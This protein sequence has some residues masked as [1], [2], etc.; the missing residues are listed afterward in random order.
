MACMVVCSS[1]CT[2]RS[3]NVIAA[4]RATEAA[5][6]EL[7]SAQVAESPCSP[8]PLV[9][10][11]WADASIIGHWF[12]ELDPL[13]WS[14]WESPSQLKQELR[15]FLDSDRPVEV[16][17]GARRDSLQCITK[18]YANAKEALRHMGADHESHV[19]HARRAGHEL[20]AAGLGFDADLSRS[21][22]LVS[23]ASYISDTEVILNWTCASCKASGFK[24][25]SGR[26]FGSGSSV[27]GFALKLEGPE[28]VAQT[29]LLAFRGT[30]DQNNLWADLDEWQSKLPDDWRCPSCFAHTGFLNYWMD[31]ESDVVN[32]LKE[33]G[34]ASAQLIITGHSLGGALATLGAWSLRQK[35]GFL[36]AAVYTYESPRV[37]TTEFADAWDT[38]I[39]ATTPAFRITF[40]SDPVTR[41]PCFWGHFV[42]VQHEVRYGAGGGFQVL[43]GRECPCDES[44]TL[45]AL[46]LHGNWTAHCDLPYVGD[47]CGH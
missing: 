8:G 3:G 25:E 15:C 31:I 46:L 42:H 27:S 28:L 7:Y 32:A 9:R 16:Q 43:R 45:S 37:A 34:C 26:H 18:T 5:R 21:L 19:M 13:R 1:F 23:K 24:I 17:I 35:H 4:A 33:L 22:A 2:S 39:A 11:M 30:S 20:E 36:L 12:A 10:W 41:I 38:R 6:T 29:C 14:P 40:Q 44:E 47:M